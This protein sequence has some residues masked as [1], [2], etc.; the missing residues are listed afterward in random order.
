MN[1]TPHF[2]TTLPVDVGG[3]RPETWRSELLAVGSARFEAAGGVIAS[4][5][6]RCRSDRAGARV[7]I[8]A[9]LLDGDEQGMP[10]SEVA[11]ASLARDRNPNLVRPAH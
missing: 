2:V 10:A 7:A 3:F 11:H 5:L 8:L 4:R 9:Q 6:V 1:L